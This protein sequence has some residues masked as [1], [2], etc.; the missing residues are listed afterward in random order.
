MY[1]ILLVESYRIP[2][3]ARTE[4]EAIYKAK[5]K[6]QSLI[7]K[8]E[9]INDG[10]GAELWFV[11]DYE[12]AFGDMWYGEDATHDQKHIVNLS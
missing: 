1:F 3:D 10:N 12:V 6:I 5:R 4:K 7:K 11:R 9:L 2:F 8:G